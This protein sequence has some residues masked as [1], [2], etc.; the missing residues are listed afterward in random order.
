M[1]GTHSTTYFRWS[2]RCWIIAFAASALFFLSLLLPL[3]VRRV[4][5]VVVPLVALI[6]CAVL[7]FMVAQGLGYLGRERRH[8][9]WRRGYTLDPRETSLPLLDL[10]TGLVIRPA[11]GS[12]A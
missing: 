3:E 9:E 5:Y 4:P 2:V 11:R 1:I 12:G 7:G 10:D 8:D 6:A